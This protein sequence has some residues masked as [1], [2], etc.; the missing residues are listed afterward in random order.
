MNIPEGPQTLIPEWLTDVLRESGIITN[1]AVAAVL[2]LN[3][4]ELL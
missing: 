1:A 4:G 2:D 3:C